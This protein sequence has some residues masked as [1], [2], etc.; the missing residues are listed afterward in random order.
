M[1]TSEKGLLA[2]RKPMV[3]S[4][5]LSKVAR[6]RLVYHMCLYKAMGKL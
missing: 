6:T 5:D 1:K 3:R 4:S 2:M